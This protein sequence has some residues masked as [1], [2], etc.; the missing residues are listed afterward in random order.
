[1]GY[2]PIWDGAFDV[3]LGDGTSL[4]DVLKSIF[5]RKM[6]LVNYKADGGAGHPE[7]TMRGTRAQFLSWLRG[8]YMVGLADRPDGDLWSEFQSAGHFKNVA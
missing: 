3:A 6:T 2:Q 7:F 4:N 5:S 8:F 1:M